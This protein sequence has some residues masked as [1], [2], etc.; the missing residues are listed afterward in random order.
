M[1]DRGSGG[2]GGRGG[3]EVRLGVVWRVS[4]DG[5]GKSGTKGTALPEGRSRVV[6]LADLRRMVKWRFTPGLIRV[7]RK[8]GRKGLGKG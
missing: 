3:Q 4:E 7:N 6:W 8:Q 2:E 1:A 5:W